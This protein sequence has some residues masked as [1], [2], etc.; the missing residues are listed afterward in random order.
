M[1]KITKFKRYLQATGMQLTLNKEIRLL[2]TLMAGRMASCQDTLMVDINLMSWTQ[3]FS[4]HLPFNYPES[5]SS[6]ELCL[7]EETNASSV[8]AA[9]ILVFNRGFNRVD[10]RS[11]SIDGRGMKPCG[12]F[13]Q[14]P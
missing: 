1:S 7:S 12:D 6:A 11:A 5:I 2:S 4:T 9:I 8:D 3:G 14:M 13:Q 10:E